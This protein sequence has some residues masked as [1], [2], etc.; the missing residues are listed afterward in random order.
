MSH[1]QT[2][3]PEQYERDAGFVADLGEPVVELLAPRP[4]ERIL[5]LGCGDGRLTEKLVAMGC[6]VV[7]ADS[8]PEQVAAARERGLDAHVVDGRE[9]PFENEFDAVFTNAA[10]HWIRPP[11]AVVAGV[12][13][14]LKPGGRF[15]GEFGGRG[16]VDAVRRRLHEA[17]AGRG[18][19][20]NVL[21]PWYFPSDSEY[22]GLLE[23][24]GF[25]VESIELFPRPTPIPTDVIGWLEM[26]GEPFTNVLP[27]TERRPFL[28]EV[29]DG[30]VEKLCD[31]AGQWTIDY[32]RLRFRAVL[33]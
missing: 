10:L 29:R 4:G 13:R 25:R 27:E 7:A 12:V 6:D 17:F 22:A 30:L 16:N 14:A 5:D 31:D 8:S 26:F 20:A 32:V 23:A 11:E 18:I 15:V 24:H 19:D 33:D 3:N 9:L 1:N 2:W 28:E 21:D